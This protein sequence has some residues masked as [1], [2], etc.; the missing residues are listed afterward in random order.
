MSEIQSSLRIAIDLT[1][2]RSGGENGGAK[3]LIL[4]LLKQFQKLAPHHSFLLLTAPWNHSELLQYETNNTECLLIPD[5]TDIPKPTKSG[6]FYK[7]LRKLSNK[8]S[9][10]LIKSINSSSFLKK[11]NI[12]LLF[13]PFSAPTYADKD[14]PLVAI[15]YD[16]QHLDYK[17]FFTHQEQQHRTKFIDELLQKSQ[18]VICISEFT[19]QSFIKYFQAPQEKFAVIPISIHERLSKLNENTVSENLINLG[20]AERKYIFYPANYWPHKNHR[21]LLTAYEIYKKQLPDGCLYLVFTGALEDEQNQLKEAA[22]V[23]GL[24]ENVKFLG[25][26]N[27]EALTSIWQGCECLVFP[28][29]YEGFGIPVL[30]GMAFGKPVL[31]SNAASLPEVGGDAVLYFDP[32]KPHEIASCLL[33]IS[34]NKLLSEELVNK[35]YQRLKLFDGEKMAS[36]YLKIFETEALNQKTSIQTSISGIY[37][38]GWSAP[39]FNI[40]IEP[41]SLGRTLEI[42]VETPSFYPASKARIKLQAKGKKASYTCIRGAS[43][44]IVWP[45]LPTGEEIT[46][47]IV[48][49]FQPSQLNL[50]SD[51]RQLG[52]IIRDCRLKLADGEFSSIFA[53]ES[54]V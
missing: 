13:C 35:G 31:S 34:N 1:P 5:L 33:S 37:D 9:L 43:Q 41:G 40:S 30:E 20:L 25:Y 8:I 23:M 32:R 51:Q 22:K 29:L 46:V 54:V 12:N 49:G 53:L 19:R 14:I 47:Q 18:K 42:V 26:L 16:L 7:L 4:T 3:V 24:S 17:F 10:K 44:K 48:P 38:D 6:L 11:H 28:S 39:E 27:D 50:N 15:A 2:L 45:V 21:M 52:L 36:Q